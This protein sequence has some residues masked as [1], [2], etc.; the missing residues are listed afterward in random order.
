MRVN[1]S[2]LDYHLPEEQIAQFPVEPR[3]AARLLVLNKKS[4]MIQHRQF[5][6]LSDYLR[7][8]DTLVLNDT[9]VTARRLFGQKPTGG[10][11]EALLLAPLPGERWRALL[12]PSKRLPEGSIVEFDGGK[13]RLRVD[14]R[15][16]DD[17]RVLCPE[18][19]SE[20]ARYVEQAGQTPLPPYIHQ[21]LA[22]PERYQTVY[23]A[24]G[25]SA[26]APTAGLHFTPDLLDNLRASGVQTVHVTLQVSLDTFRPVQTERLEDHKI[27]GEQILLSE[28]AAEAINQ[29]TGRIYAVGTTAA[30]TLESAAIGIRRVKP[31][32]GE[33][34]LF[35]TPGYDFQVVEGLIT[36]FHMPRT[37]VLALVAA[38]AGREPL[39]NAYDEAIRA[40]YRFLSFGDAMLIAPE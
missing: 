1:V 36:N 16:P 21:S 15:L 32:Y 27:H 33:T 8:G 39:L 22:N 13:I 11:V 31:F 35:I 28:E 17:S 30:R 19:P 14:D 26:A 23:A 3:D 40:G 2:L 25:G 4:G 18:I 38:L 24:H 12:K 34:R 10:A 6:D 37:T 9:R 29:S 7:K 5:S 20:F